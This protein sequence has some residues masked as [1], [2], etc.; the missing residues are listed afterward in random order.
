MRG[1]RLVPGRWQSLAERPMT[2]ANGSVMSSPVEK[3]P[4]YIPLFVYL[5][6]FSPGRSLFTF[7]SQIVVVMTC[8]AGVCWIFALS[9]T[10]V[11]GCSCTTHLIE[12]ISCVEGKKAVG[13]ALQ[14][15]GDFLLKV[16][17]VSLH[18]CFK[19]L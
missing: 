3:T 7:T 11:L 10:D 14:C 15:G 9:F 1:G 16:L 19:S 4:F 2:I 5:M 13:Q 6:G 17:R 12:V 8:F 18:W